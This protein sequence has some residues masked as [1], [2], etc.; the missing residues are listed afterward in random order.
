VRGKAAGLFMPA[1]YPAMCT[2]HRYAV[3]RM[4]VSPCA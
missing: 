2:R 1:Q 3:L 4:G